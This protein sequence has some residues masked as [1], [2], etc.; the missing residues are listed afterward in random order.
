MIFDERANEVNR[1]QLNMIAAFT[2][3]FSLRDGHRILTFSHAGT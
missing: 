2:P 3:G 1:P